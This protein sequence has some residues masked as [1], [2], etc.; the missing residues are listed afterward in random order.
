MLQNTAFHD[1][2]YQLARIIDINTEGL[3]LELSENIFL[4]KIIDDM[5]FLSRTMQTLFTEIQHLSHLPE[6]LPILHCLYSCE[7]R[8]LLLLKS[9][10]AKVIEK[11]LEL[12]ISAADLTAYHKIHTEIKEQIEGYVHDADKNL[13]SYQMVSKNELSELLSF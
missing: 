5:R 12:P 4:E 10:A 13:D 2:L 3:R 1:N 11:K 9:F 6:Y 8:Y 7:T